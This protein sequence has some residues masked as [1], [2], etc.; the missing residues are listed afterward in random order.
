MREK[1]TDLNPSF[2]ITANLFPSRSKSPSSTPVSTV[3]S[4]VSPLSKLERGRRGRSLRV[5]G[6]NVEVLK[7]TQKLV[8]ASRS[9][10]EH[11]QSSQKE[12]LADV[13]KGKMTPEIDAKLKKVVV[14]C[15]QP[16]LSMFETSVLTSPFSLISQPRFLLCLRLS[17]SVLKRT[18][19]DFHELRVRSV[20][21][22]AFIRV[23]SQFPKSIVL[24]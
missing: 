12:L 1:L 8:V 18:C 20:C 2:G 7:L 19:L 17:V 14:E 15:V 23:W 5:I 10:K 11:L 9:F 24:C 3:S 16:S 13:G 21:V 22:C 4:I 6:K